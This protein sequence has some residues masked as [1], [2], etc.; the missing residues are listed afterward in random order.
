M[1]EAIKLG[2]EIREAIDQIEA[3]YEFMLAYAAQ[4]RRNESEAEGTSQIRSFLEQFRQALDS[5]E[6][7]IPILCPAG[8]AGQA[9]G[10]RFAADVRVMQ[11]ILD[12]LL[13]H[14][15]ISSDMIDNTN[16]LIAVRALLT[17]LFFVDQVLLP[18]Y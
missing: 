4:G 11:S 10:E 12:L 9:F 6:Q 2:T 8:K 18:A 17:D 14:K 13:E 3:A 15:S 5:I 1:S 16:G 7:T